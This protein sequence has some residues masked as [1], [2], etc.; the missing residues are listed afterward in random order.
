[1]GVTIGIESVGLDHKG[2]SPNQEITE[3]RARADTRM[4]MMRC[5]RRRE[6]AALL[7]LTGQE[8]AIVW[9]EDV[10]EDYGANRLSVF[11][12]E[13]CRRLART[14]GLR[15]GDRPVKAPDRSPP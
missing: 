3:T 7:G 14:P 10:V 6:E 9:N 8:D 11:G 4:P 5:V 1:M 12:G 13:L 15:E 2:S